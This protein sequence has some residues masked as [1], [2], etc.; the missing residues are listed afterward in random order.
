PYNTAATLSW[1]VTNATSCNASGDWSG[2]KSAAGGF[3]STGNLTSSKTYNITCTGPGGTASDSVGATV[4]ILPP[5]VDIKANNLN[6]PITISYNTS[7]LL[8]W[9]TTNNPTSCVASGSWFGSKSV[10]TGSESTGNLTA[11]QNNYVLTCSNTAGS[12]SDSV[13]VQVL[14][15]LAAPPGPP[16]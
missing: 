4:Q 3:E 1:T 10:P 9:T 5:T 14:Y 6:G 12:H 2:A 16:L 13:L 15:C 11:T 7:A 8:S